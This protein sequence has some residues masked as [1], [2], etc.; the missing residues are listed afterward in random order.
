[1]KTLIITPLQEEFNFIAQSYLRRRFD[2][3]KSMVGRL[4]VV[5]FP[6]LGITMA[7]GGL[8]KAQFALQTQ[9]LLDVCSDWDVVVCA[10]GTGGLND[11]L[12]IGDVVV[13]TTTIEHDFNNK[14]GPRQFPRFEGELSCIADLKQAALRTLSFTVHFGTIASGDEDVVDIDRR[15]YLRDSMG[16]LAVAWEG[17]GGARAC[18]FSAIP[19]VEI[20]GVTDAAN[21][22]A[23]S[24]FKTNLEFAMDNVATL[25]A[26]WLVGKTPRG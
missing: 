8:G 5:G 23:P 16:A 11:R 1:M 7:Q 25:I 12:S 17:A 21:H 24:D 13:A 19:F 6:D 15:Q 22:R 20:R 9:H 18:K 2:F 14:F 3:G 26:N 4:P 10:G